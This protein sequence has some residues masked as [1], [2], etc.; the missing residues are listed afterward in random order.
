MKILASGQ[1]RLSYARRQSQFKL[2]L[3]S[4]SAPAQRLRDKV[5]RLYLSRPIDLQLRRRCKAEVCVSLG[6]RL[7]PE[8]F[9][10]IC[11]PRLCV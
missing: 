9:S 2:I 4:R 7:R 3:S 1:A 8:N 10:R 6:D 5:T 11:W